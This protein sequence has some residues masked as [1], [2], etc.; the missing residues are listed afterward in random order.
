M[1][2]LLAKVK[3]AKAELFDGYTKLD[4]AGLTALAIRI[5]VSP[6]PEVER[7]RELLGRQEEEIGTAAAALEAYQSTE[8][9]PVGLTD[10]EEA[11]H[12]LM[13][14]IAEAVEED[15]SLKGPIKRLF[16][17]LENLIG[18]EPEQ[19]NEGPRYPAPEG[20]WLNPENGYPALLR[21]TKSGVCDAGRRFSF[22]AGQRIRGEKAWALWD[23]YHDSVVA[24][25]RDGRDVG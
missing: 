13:S 21:V 25:D 18:D 22:R 17:E 14:E 16:T 7:M 6:D 12:E 15:P 1:K 10:E 8:S 20:A 4:E 5:G 11:V 24:L 19:P 2:E 23:H 9:V 3:A